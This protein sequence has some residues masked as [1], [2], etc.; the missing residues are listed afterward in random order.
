[1]KPCDKGWK[2]MC[3]CNCDNQ[4]PLFKHPLNGNQKQGLIED[5]LKIGKGPI[6][7]QMGWVCHIKFEE[8]EKYVFF[9]REHGMC[10]LWQERK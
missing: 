1:M 5:K 3:C 4:K 7:E 2:G 8:E 6:S 10:E 9:D